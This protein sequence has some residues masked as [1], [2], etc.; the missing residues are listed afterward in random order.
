VRHQVSVISVAFDHLDQQR[1]A[2]VVILQSLAAAV[3]QRVWV[4]HRGVD[5]GDGAGQRFKVLRQVTLIGAEYAFV[6]SS[7]RGTEVIFE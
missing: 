3:K 4:E 5:A 1:H 6:F 7:E 2:L